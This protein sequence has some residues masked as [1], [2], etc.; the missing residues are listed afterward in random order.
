MT[1][2]YA[3]FSTSATVCGKHKCLVKHATYLARSLVVDELAIGM[4]FG[5]RRSF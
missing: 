4:E 3:L 2:E 1:G 5:D